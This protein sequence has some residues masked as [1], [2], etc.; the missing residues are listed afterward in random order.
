ML[1]M[2]QLLRRLIVGEF[3]QEGDPRAIQADNVRA[4]RVQLIAEFAREF[5][6]GLCEVI[7]ADRG[8][9]RELVDQS[10]VIGGFKGAH[11]PLLDNSALTL[12]CGLQPHEGRKTSKQIQTGGAGSCIYA[13][14]DKQGCA[15]DECGADSA[16]LQGARAVLA[17]ER[18]QCG[19]QETDLAGFQGLF[20]AEYILGLHAGEPRLIINA[21]LLTGGLLKLHLGWR[22]GLFI[23]L[24]L[25]AELQLP[26]KRGRHVFLQETRSRVTAG[27]QT[28]VGMLVARYGADI[29]VELARAL[30][31][32]A[33]ND[34]FARN[35]ARHIGDHSALAKGT[36]FRRLGESATL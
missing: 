1:Q 16:E 30:L 25:L 11:H 5:R 9:C 4:V 8:L 36:G 34:G 15:V 24:N 18:I 14:M 29:L 23:V 22:G 2:T 21:A 17:E 10:S 7:F 13:D 12:L 26:P 6:Q 27:Q 32:H 19:R 20:V 28:E 33:H 31:G 35:R 3:R